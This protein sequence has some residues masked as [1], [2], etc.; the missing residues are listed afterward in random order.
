MNPQS[1]FRLGNRRQAVPENG[2][3]SIRKF[4]VV[5]LIGI[6]ATL[7]LLTQ[8]ETIVYLIGG[9]A[10]FLGMFIC[11][12]LQVYASVRKDSSLRSE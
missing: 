3:A 9:G 2:T 6:V 11:R 4:P 8:F 1:G 5:P 7:A 10:V 12:I